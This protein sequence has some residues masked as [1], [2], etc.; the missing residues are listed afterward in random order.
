MINKAP[1]VSKYFSVTVTESRPAQV[2]VTA[3][4]CEA[5]LDGAE[6]AGA[7]P[8]PALAQRRL[9]SRMYRHSPNLRLSLILWPAAMIASLIVFVA[10]PVC[11]RRLN[12]DPL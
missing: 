7:G 8:I 9:E 10:H 6:I 3:P 4:N 5:P 12:L 1:P 11:R 2:R